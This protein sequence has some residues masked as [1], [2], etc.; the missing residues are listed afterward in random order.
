MGHAFTARH[1]RAEQRHAIE[2]ALWEALRALEESASLYRRMA[3]R[4]H[5]SNH[6]Q[7]MMVYQERAENAENNS[8]TLRDFLVQVNGDETGNYEIEEIES[9]EKVT[10]GDAAEAF[11]KPWRAARSEY[12]SGVTSFPEPA[13]PPGPAGPSD[14]TRP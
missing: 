8:R 9:K 13:F 3:T 2:T 4:A 5:N 1:L 7:S 14:S 11:R 10:D 12:A 6:D